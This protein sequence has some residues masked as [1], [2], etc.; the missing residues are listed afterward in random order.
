MINRNTP[1]G[2][3]LYLYIDGFRQMT[4]GRTLWAVIIVKSVVLLTVLQLFFPD[5][6]K[7]RAEG[8]EAD[9]VAEEL[10]GDGNRN[11]D[12]NNNDG[13]NNND[14]ENLTENRQINNHR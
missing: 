11:D 2:K 3:F 10:L 14:D 7:T 9:Y 8:R 1:I 4:T 5:T 6:I 12:E 13:E